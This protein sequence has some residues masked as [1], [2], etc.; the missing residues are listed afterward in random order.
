MSEAA[1]VPM[2]GAAPAEPAR[3]RTEGGPDLRLAAILFAAIPA[4]AFLVCG[5]AFASGTRGDEM[6]M[7]VIAMFTFVVGVL[8]IA[9]QALLPASRRHLFI[10]LFALAFLVYFVLPV[11]PEY[12]W[13]DHEGF[14]RDRLINIAPA[15]IVN[16]Q[17]AA[18]VALCS[19]LAG[20][21]LPLGKVA[22]A[23]LP[24]PRYDWGY[25]NTL[26]IAVLMIAF[27][28]LIFLLGQFGLLP[29]DLGTGFLGTLSSSYYLGN[30]MLVIA[31]LRHRS[32]A[33]V[34]LLLVM[35]PPSMGFAFFTGSKKLVL[36]PLATIALA[37]IVT[38]RR[39]RISWFLGGLVAITFLYPIAQFYRDVVQVGN[40][41]GAVEVLRNPG[42]AIGL[43]SAFVS[44]V[45]W[46]EYL[47]AG[48]NAT[49]SRMSALGILSVIVRDTPD[50]V[51]FQGGWTVG[52]VFISYIPR[53]VWPDKPI[54]TIG[55]WVTDNYG[56]GPIVTSQTG[57]SQVGEL[58]F[59][60]GWPGIILGMLVIGMLFRLMSEM[61]FRPNAPTVAL[62]TAVTALWTILL[63]L[64]G[65]LTG[66]INGFVFALIPIVAAHLIV[67]FVLGGRPAA[68][69]AEPYSA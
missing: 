2:S 25:A 3:R 16:G 69:G 39:V 47:L 40:Q 14:Q 29:R 64:Q 62:I 43:L 5:I 7:V 44:S 32:R 60:F 23:V 31:A 33:A 26:L 18:L 28:W 56:A 6:T 37:H 67:R 9:V 8:P 54:T 59:N 55:Q 12:F 58:F 22:A 49:S 57:P 52:L 65:A 10:S 21:A 17:L 66:L 15:D 38:T 11:F 51:P 63:S 13:S 20:F 41:L 68:R 4:V 50:A 1:P 27:G 34:L 45:D 19:V 42:R 46:G 36:A 48:L 24:S 30:G 61:V 53:I 35:L